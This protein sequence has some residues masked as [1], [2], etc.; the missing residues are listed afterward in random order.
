MIIGK[1]TSAAASPVTPLLRQIYVSF[2]YNKIDF[3][4][5]NAGIMPNPQVN[6]KALFRGLFSR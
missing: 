5:L 3:L 2:R 4:Y 6:V 1:Y